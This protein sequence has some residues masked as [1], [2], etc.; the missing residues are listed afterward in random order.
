M[1]QSESYRDKVRDLTDEDESDS[2][3]EDED[4]GSSGSEDEAAAEE[5]RE[6][7]RRRHEERRIKKEEREARKK[8][9]KGKGSLVDQIKAR[10]ADNVTS[11]GKRRAK[12]TEDGVGG[13][14]GTRIR[15]TH[16]YNVGYS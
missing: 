9:K 6:E 4:E 10:K 2:E 12:R 14:T 11:V 1:P 16:A 5:R 3:D 8:A 13:A 7:R 15:R